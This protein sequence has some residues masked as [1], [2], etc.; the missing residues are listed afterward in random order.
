MT[1]RTRQTLKVTGDWSPTDAFSLNVSLE[2]GKDSY[3]APADAGLNETK[4]Q[5]YNVDA[6][7]KL[8]DKWKLTGYASFGKQN[9]NMQ[10]GI[11]Y[12]ADMQQRNFAMGLGIVG[13][14]KAGL[15]VGGEVSYLEDKQSYN[16][17]TTTATAVSNLPDNSY[18]ATLLKFYGKVALDKKSD[19]RFDLI[20]QWA[21][22]NDWNW[23]YNGVP[24]TYSDNSTVFLQPTQNVTFVGVRYIYRFR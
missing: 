2:D 18:R 20:Q 13:T 16:L 24:F 11:G 15:E 17:S 21:R 10:Q 8:S 14:L 22:Y 9:L 6:V 7:L 1:D 23:G 19:L 3:D 5:F 12:I 4:V